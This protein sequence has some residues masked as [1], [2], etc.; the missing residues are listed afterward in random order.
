MAVKDLEVLR[1]IR[2]VEVAEDFLENAKVGIDCALEQLRAGITQARYV[3]NPL[4]PQLE[5]M[6]ATFAG[7]EAALNGY[8]AS[9]KDTSE[10][11]V[12]EE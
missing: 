12:D 5:A 11:D 4:I 3:T 6:S 8:V 2:E 1:A 9:L 7:W 10:D